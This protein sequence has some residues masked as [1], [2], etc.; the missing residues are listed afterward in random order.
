[1]WQLCCTSQ[2]HFHHCRMPCWTALIYKVRMMRRLTLWILMRIKWNNECWATWHSTSGRVNVNQGSLWWWKWRQGWWRSVHFHAL[3]H[4]PSASTREELPPTK[5]VL[6]W[7]LVASIKKPGF[8]YQYRV[9]I[10]CSRPGSVTGF[11]WVTDWNQKWSSS[12]RSCLYV[13]VT[14][15]CLTLCDPM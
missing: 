12:S 3:S 7:T 15:S 5:K 10:L 9:L 14:Q 4:H 1:M 11:Q 6:E 8:I 13:L 2:N